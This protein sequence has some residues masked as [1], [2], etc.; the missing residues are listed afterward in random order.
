MLK[1]LWRNA[2][3]HCEKGML[4]NMEED[5]LFDHRENYDGYELKWIPGQKKLSANFSKGVLSL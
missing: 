1:K 3:F 5:E 2:C 4:Y